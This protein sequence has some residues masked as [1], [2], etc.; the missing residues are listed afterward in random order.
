MW[1]S[2]SLGVWWWVTLVVLGC[3]WCAS[4]FQLPWLLWIWALAWGWRW[5]S[6]C[7]LD[8]GFYVFKVIL[9]GRVVVGRWW[10]DVKYMWLAMG[11][12]VLW[13]WVR[14]CLVHV[15]YFP[16][17][18]FYVKGKHVRLFDYVVKIM[19]ENYFLCLVLHVKNPFSENETQV[20]PQPTLGPA[21]ATTKEKHNSPPTTQNPDREEEKKAPIAPL[22]P[23]STK[24]PPLKPPQ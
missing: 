11:M 2:T 3:V 24:T 10:L 6:V 21:T 9:R 20:S 5:K 13:L 12:S 17:M 19:P 4:G 22:P 18:L 14:L 8:L 7:E 23:K 16:K 15:K 1:W